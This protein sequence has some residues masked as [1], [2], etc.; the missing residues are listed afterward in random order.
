MYPENIDRES[1]P[2]AAVGSR[3]IAA[4]AAAGREYGP[5]TYHRIAPAYIHA[6]I[7][8]YVEQTATNLFFMPRHVLK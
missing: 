3:S 5:T 4:G 7:D 6:H 1:S 8:T 2:A